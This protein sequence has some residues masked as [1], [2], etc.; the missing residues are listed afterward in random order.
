MEVDN[1]N[2]P[3]STPAEDR[4]KSGRTTRRPDTFSQSTHSILEEAAGGKRKRSDADGSEGEDNDESDSDSDDD[5]SDDEADEEELR[6][7]KLAARKPAQRKSTARKGP[8]ASKKP[9]VAGNGVRKQLAF[10][11]ALNGRLPNSRWLNKSKVRPSLAAG[12]HGIFG[13]S[14]CPG[15]SMPDLTWGI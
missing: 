14:C 5:T 1:L 9:K 12:E 13:E 11:P 3:S 2:D 8:R 7:K 15:A 6:A 10:R 4:R